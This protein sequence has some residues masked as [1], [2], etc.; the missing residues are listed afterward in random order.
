MHI[1]HTGGC[2]GQKLEEVV[3]TENQNITKG[4][5]GES[6]YKNLKQGKTV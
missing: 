1:W 2:L 3:N 5:E 6:S 4:C